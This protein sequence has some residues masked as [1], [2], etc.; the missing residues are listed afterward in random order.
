MGPET[1]VFLPSRDVVFIEIPKVACT[2]IKVA[3]ARLLG[4]RLEGGNPH[5]T[6]FPSVAYE[7]SDNGPLYPG[8]FSFAFVRN[9]WDRLVSCYRD[10][11]LLAVKG[12]TSSTIRPGIANC[13]ARF[14][15]FRPGMS[16][17]AFVDAV[18]SI[19]DERAD[20]HFR[21]QYTFITNRSSTVAIDFVGRFEALAA[22]LARVQQLANLP[23]FQL[24]RLQAAPAWVGYRELYDTRGRDL[25]ADRFHTD[26]RLF[27]YDF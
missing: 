26:I 17:P 14:D 24:P 1:S 6:Q 7:L 8:R 16:F 4:I 3:L 15:E 25:V 10:K 13:L 12:Y 2:S 18:V 20:D 22:D 11:I 19:P 5:E 9:P 21:S 23:K 27:G